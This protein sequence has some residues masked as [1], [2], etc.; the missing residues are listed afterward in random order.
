MSAPEVGAVSCVEP[1]GVTGRPRGALQC[2]GM[3]ARNLSLMEAIKIVPV[4]N[5]G[6][7]DQT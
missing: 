1:S 5:N 6:G 7:S 4:K 2:H 3:G